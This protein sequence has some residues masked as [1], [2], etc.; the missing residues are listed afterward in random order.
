MEINDPK[1]HPKAYVKAVNLL[2]LSYIY[3]FANYI[4]PYY[5][6]VKEE[7]QAGHM[8]LSLARDIKQ[9][10]QVNF[11]QNTFSRKWKRYATRCYEHQAKMIKGSL[12]AQCD[13][14]EHKRQSWHRVF[15]DKKKNKNVHTIEPS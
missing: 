11:N 4:K 6:S 7:V 8:S 1:F 10:Y 12:C 3:T 14:H 2:T 5:P 13:P 15:F 9:L